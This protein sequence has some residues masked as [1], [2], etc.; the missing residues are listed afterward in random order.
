MGLKRKTL[1]QQLF[2]H[3]YRYISNRTTTVGVLTQGNAY[4]V[5]LPKIMLRP[6]TRG[7]HLF[8]KIRKS[9]HDSYDS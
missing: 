5:F 1:S 8:K 4:Q 7:Q 2:K 3:G 9:N 6:L